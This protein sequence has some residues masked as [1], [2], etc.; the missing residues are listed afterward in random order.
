MNSIPEPLARAFADK[1]IISSPELCRLLP[2]DR[3]AL[4]GH[5]RAGHIEY[6]STG[7]GALHPRC[8]FTL[9]AV[10]E[11]LARRSRVECRSTSTSA[12][13]STTTTSSGEGSGIRALRDALLA[14]KE[15]ARS[16]AQAGAA[17]QTTRPNG[18]GK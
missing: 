12:R 17:R 10:I 3:E 9:A 15:Q 2:I 6:V 11:F 16:S 14:G 5:V 4:R 1:V 8:R 7:G 13:R 18:L